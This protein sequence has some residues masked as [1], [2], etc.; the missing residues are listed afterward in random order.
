MPPG[1]PSSAHP[2]QTVRTGMGADLKHLSLAG[3]PHSCCRRASEKSCCYPDPSP[4]SASMVWRPPKQS[5][6]SRAPPRLLAEP[7]GWAVVPSRTQTDRVREGRFTAVQG[8]KGLQV[9][10]STPCPQK[11]AFI[12]SVVVGWRWQWSWWRE[13]ERPLGLVWG[14]AEEGRQLGWVLPLPS[15]FQ[16]WTLCPRNSDLL[17]KSR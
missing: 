2:S 1:S 13:E 6:I 8:G 12:E 5:P 3:S 4:A 10:Q 15:T 9:I 14:E 11:K 16:A 7:Y 17:A